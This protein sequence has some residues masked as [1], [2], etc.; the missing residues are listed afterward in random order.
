MMHESYRAA[1][2]SFAW[3]NTFRNNE[4]YW[5]NDIELQKLEWK[6]KRNVQ[7]ELQLHL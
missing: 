2:I 4:M 5:S 1:I 6:K 3:R 7:S